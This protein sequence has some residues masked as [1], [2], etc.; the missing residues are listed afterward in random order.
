MTQQV[1]LLNISELSGI[2]NSLANDDA[3]NIFIAAQKGITKSTQTIKE[4]ELTQKRYYT[5]LGSLMKV[6]LVERTNIGYEMTSLGRLIHNV[7]INKVRFA[8]V[9]R[10]K[11]ELMDKLKKTVLLSPEDYEKVSFSILQNMNT[12]FMPKEMEIC[13]NI[14]QFV[15]YS[16]KLIEKGEEEVYVASRFFSPSISEAILNCTN[17]NVKV[18][19]LDGDTENLSSK[20]QIIRTLL[21]NPKTIDRFYKA[22]ESRNLKLRFAA[23]PFTFFLVDHE[24]VGIEIADVISGDFFCGLLFKD[25]EIYTNLKEKFTI[26]FEKALKEPVI[27]VN[28]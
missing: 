14:N 28:G 4:L 6:G 17:R 5:R 18:F 15:L 7:L 3:L 9:N 22:L 23:L 13:R 26:L 16:M 21:S 12:F 8:L 1:E 19:I 11:I 2:L 27:N 10:D 25:K 24:Y 20:I